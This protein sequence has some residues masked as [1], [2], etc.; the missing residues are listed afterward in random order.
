M[1]KAGF[2]CGRKA[3]NL[4]WTGRVAVV[5]LERGLDV[6]GKPWVLLFATLECNLDPATRIHGEAGHAVLIQEA[7]EVAQVS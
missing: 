7:E 5:V 1:P 4:A 2:S 6:G 3:A